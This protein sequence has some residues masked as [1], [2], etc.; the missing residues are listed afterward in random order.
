MWCLKLIYQQKHLEEKHLEVIGK[1]G[2]FYLTD[3][4]PF[5]NWSLILGKNQPKLG[6]IKI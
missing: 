2:K 1:F 6:D 3:F 5:K 4:I